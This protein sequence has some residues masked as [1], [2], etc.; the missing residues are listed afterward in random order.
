LIL[1][2]NKFNN[3]Y[4]LCSNER[5]VVQLGTTTS[6]TASRKHRELGRDQNIFIAVIMRLLFFLKMYERYLTCRGRHPLQTC[7]PL[8]SRPCFPMRLLF[9]LKMY[10]R[11]LTCRERDP[12]Q[13]CY[14]LCFPFYKLTIPHRVG[15]PHRGV[16]RGVAVWV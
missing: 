6:L 9:F 10:E 4:K 3:L 11:Y 1:E 14:P 8:W 16:H 12:L 7:Y 15:I 5:G 2:E 13:T